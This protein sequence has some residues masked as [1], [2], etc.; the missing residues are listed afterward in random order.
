MFRPGTRQNVQRPLRRAALLAAALIVLWGASQ[1]V[2]A[3]RSA[4]PDPASKAPTA[5]ARTQEVRRSYAGIRPGY[6][7]AFLL[8]AGGAGFAIY[9]RRK[10]G[11]GAAK[12]DL[13]HP[14]GKLQLGPGQS[15]HLVACGDEVLVLGTTASNVT[16]LKTMPAATVS[17]PGAAPETLTAS[18]D[19]HA[20]RSYRHEKLVG[21]HLEVLPQPGSSL[22]AS[23]TPFSDVLRRFGSS[24]HA[25]ARRS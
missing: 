18:T 15:V 12:R 10:N 7:A 21:A 1:F 24:A 14:I 23:R 3:P 9:L 20:P 13:L 5:T 4:P 19:A 22:E 25:N 2:S 6:V 11:G 17:S 8:L 16:L